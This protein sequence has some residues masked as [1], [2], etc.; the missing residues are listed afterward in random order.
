MG[1]PLLDSGGPDGGDST[2]IDIY[3][4]ANS[5][6]Q[7]ERD[8]TPRSLGSYE[9]I[10]VPTA[11]I[12][13]TT[14]SS[15]FILMNRTA[16]GTPDFRTDF[17]HEFFHVLQDKSNWGPGCPNWWY[18]D[19]SA[20]WAEEYFDP[21]DA[22]SE[23]DIANLLQDFMNDS[24]QSL[25]KT[26][27]SYEAF[28]WPYFQAQEQGAAAI[29]QTWEAAAGLQSCDDLNN[30]LNSVF[31]FADHF[32]DFAVRNLDYLFPRPEGKAEVPRN[33]G[34]TYQEALSSSGVPQS[35]F[36]RIFPAFNY[37]SFTSP[38]TQPVDLNLPPLS[39]EYI[40]VQT[41]TAGSA[42]VGALQLNIAGLT[43]TGNL[44][45][46][47]IGIS[48]DKAKAHWT[49]IRDTSPTDG[50]CTL[51]DNTTDAELILVLTNSSTTNTVAGTANIQARPNCATSASGTITHTQHTVTNLND[52]TTV[53]DDTV[54]AH[55][56][57]KS[58]P[59]GGLVISQAPYTYSFS[60]SITDPNSTCQYSGSGS[61]VMTGAWGV[62]SAGGA[63]L[64]GYDTS[65][66]PFLNEWAHPKTPATGCQGG[67]TLDDWARGCPILP[68]G[69]LNPAPDYAGK[70]T[71]KRAKVNLS[72]HDSWSDAN[73][74]QITESFTGSLTAKGVIPCGLY[75][76][77]CVNGKPK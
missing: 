20:T 24:S 31:P 41:L 75:T 12:P 33:F 66:A 29:P 43:N 44:S 71:N 14:F 3:L 9:A 27:S 39:T 64:Q 50:V 36:P 38:G 73:G 37:K 59:E 5:S 76:T 11:I 69:A 13:D 70:Y 1:E 55:L 16:L 30:A 26:P 72:C 32:R 10:T 35:T 58:N 47:T 15:A 40:D 23:G 60:G 51:W 18:A 52:V 68:P 28:I 4:V 65:H 53:L 54:T 8:G 77:Y 49:R 67:V 63:D 34:P 17:I 2:A 45:L 62:G 6:Q 19:A 7:V 21:T 22:D 56:N 42:L 61:A 25:F 46:D 48:D 57:L 74:N